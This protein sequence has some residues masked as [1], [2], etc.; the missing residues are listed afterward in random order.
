MEIR[1][2]KILI[3]SCL[4]VFGFSPIFFRA[5]AQTQQQSQTINNTCVHGKLF[6]NYVKID[7]PESWKQ[8]IP[9]TEERKNLSAKVFTIPECGRTAG[10]GVLSIEFIKAYDSFKFVRIIRDESSRFYYENSNMNHSNHKSSVLTYSTSH[11]NFVIFGDYPK[12][13]TMYDFFNFKNFYLDYM[14]SGNR[15]SISIDK[16]DNDDS[17]IKICIKNYQSDYCIFSR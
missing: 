12:T 4:A 2:K 16:L 3:G 7:A 14:Y 17:E 8:L 5:E 15:S 1:M 13:D 9:S 10:N 6:G 11:P